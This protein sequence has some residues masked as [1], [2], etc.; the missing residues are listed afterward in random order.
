MLNLESL[1]E[2]NFQRV[3]A[4]LPKMYNVDSNGNPLFKIEPSK[5]VWLDGLHFLSC[6][7][8]DLSFRCI[9]IFLIWM[10]N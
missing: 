6:S 8:K 1:N 4:L 3:P 7:R 5:E 10:G 2:L 9:M